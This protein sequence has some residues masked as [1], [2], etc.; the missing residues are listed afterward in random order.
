MSDY[1][2]KFVYDYPQTNHRPIG[3]WGRTRNLHLIFQ[4]GR[5]NKNPLTFHGPANYFTT[6][7]ALPP[8]RTIT[9]SNVNMNVRVV[10]RNPGGGGPR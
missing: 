2:Y 3:A 8:G 6:K 10:P 9:W 4:R 5:D 1:S 7:R